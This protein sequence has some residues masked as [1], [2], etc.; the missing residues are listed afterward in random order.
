MGAVG[1]RLVFPDGR[2]QE[3]GSIIWNDGSCLGYGRGD[4]PTAPQ[5][6]YV[7]DVDYCSAAFLL[8]PRDVFFELGEFD[9]R[10]Q[11]AYYEDAD[12]CVR[13]WKAGRRVV[14]DPRVLVTHFEFA[15]STS[16]AAAT[17]MQLERRALFAD[18]HHEWLAGQVP[19]ATDGVLRAR[20]RHRTGQRILVIDDRVPHASVGFGDPRAIALLRSLVD[21]GHSVT[22][23]P[24]SVVDEDWARIY[25]DIPREV[26]VLR[27]YG[28]RRLV[29]LFRERA[30][31]YDCIIVS[32][33]H[34]M[35]LLRAKLGEPGR[36]MRDTRVIYDAEAITAIRDVG[37]RRL[38]GEDVRDAEA[39]RLVA[40][41]LDLARGVDAVLAVSGEE[42]RQFEGVAAGRVHVV[43]HAVEVTPTMRP[44][45]ERAGI[46]FV[47]AFHE[48]SPNGDAA[49]WFTKHVLP[50]LRA[51]V[52]DVRFT[53][54]GQDPPAELIGLDA[55]G[56]RVL[57]GVADLRPLY[58]EA[59]VFVA[60]TRFASGIP[61]KVIH[62]AA[63]GLP[64]VATSLLAKQLAWQ[65]GRELLQADSPDD[66]AIACATL[67][68]DPVLWDRVRTN[69]L[70]R[71]AGDYSTDAFT[72]ALGGA[73]L[74]CQGDE[75]IAR[76]R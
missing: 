76:R 58:D 11:P 61:L 37:R 40:A 13:L 55:E 19:P 6:S 72:N 63:H 9:G 24:V 29:P 20:D 74:A 17:A 22:L 31:Y 47:G 56:V 67:H 23:F 14:Y 62:A 18:V 3:A 32:R 42:Q 51:R 39:N 25:E 1:G 50:A 41:E 10:Y 70:G 71:T 21:L 75:L 68:E 7:R 64:V 45:H 2:L 48:L 33:S 4:S 8:T 30:G 53:I 66:F 65:D 43:G 12:Y 52:G 38:L 16:S 26:E 57:G 49:I 60:P 69:A 15:S 5:Y 54:V 44:F 35:A 73:L 34:N 36:W 59:R 27:G 28:G 46:L